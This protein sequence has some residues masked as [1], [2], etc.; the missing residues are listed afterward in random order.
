MIKIVGCDG[1]ILYYGRV[2]ELPIKEDYILAQS[3]EVYQEKD[4]CIIYRTHIIK[5]FLLKLY[6]AL[7]ETDDNGIAC[8]ELKNYFK[9]LDLTFQDSNRYIYHRFQ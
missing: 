5:R 6:E 8:L 7:K 2:M 4:P 9:E 3:L 1:T